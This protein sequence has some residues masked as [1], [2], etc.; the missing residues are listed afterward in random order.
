MLLRLRKL[1]KLFLVNTVSVVI[2]FTSLL[3][4]K[5][6]MLDILKDYGK[7]QLNPKEVARVLGN[8]LKLT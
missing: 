4:R 1:K 7:T 8:D 5:Q 6:D 2:L 3:F